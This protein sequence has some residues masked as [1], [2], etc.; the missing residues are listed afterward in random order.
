MIEFILEF[1]VK[2][3]VKLVP[4]GGRIGL[5]VVV[6]VGLEERLVGLD[7]ARSP[8]LVDGLD[9]FLI[10]PLSASEEEGRGKG[11]E[12]LLIESID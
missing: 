4:V 6:L 1:E 9:P 2:G 10:D 12:G 8:R 5:R 7:L 3:S 11:E